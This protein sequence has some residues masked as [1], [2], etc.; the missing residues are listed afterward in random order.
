M[1][2]GFA[3]TIFF[4]V[5]HYTKIFEDKQMASSFVVIHGDNPL[6]ISPTNPYEFTF[7]FDQDEAPH[8]RKPAVLYLGI[9][10]LVDIT[11]V[12]LNGSSVGRLYPVLDFS[13]NSAL[14]SPTYGNNNIYLY[15]GS[16]GVGAGQYNFNTVLKDLIVQSLSTVGGY[17]IT[18]TVN[19][20]MGREINEFADSVS[21]GEGTYEAFYYG[22]GVNRLRL[23]AA[24]QPF[25]VKDIIMH[26][27]VQ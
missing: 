11:E 14:S 8:P 22:S 5:S 9:Q 7:G 24:S 18:Q 1:L 12:S 2:E 25:R 19:I 3:F 17:W 23:E 13:V 16:G 26:Y 27:P 15:A 6:E 10:G 4:I 20:N 21:E